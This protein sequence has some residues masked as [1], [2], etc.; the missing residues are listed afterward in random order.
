MDLATALE[1]IEQQDAE[2][3]ELRRHVDRLE[4]TIAITAA[5]LTGAADCCAVRDD[6]L[7][8]GAG[9]ELGVGTDRV[10]SGLPIHYIAS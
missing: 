3:D 5:L 2:L 6:D 7:I 10:G 1:R 9:G 8:G 4:S